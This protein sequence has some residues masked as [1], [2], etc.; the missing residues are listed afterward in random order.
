M[1]MKRLQK[2]K[3]IFH[4]F[5][6]A[7]Y[8]ALSLMAQNRAQFQTQGVRAMVL[9]VCL[10]L[11]LWIF[12]RLVVRDMEKA[13]LITSLT[14]ILFF[15]YGHVKNVI[16]ASRLPLDF[17]AQDAFLAPLWL[18]ILGFW[19]YWVVKKDMS[20]AR[21][22]SYFNGVG[23]I[24]ILFPLYSL[25]T[26]RGQSV[27]VDP[28][29][30][31][32]VA[33]TWLDS[34]VNDLEDRMASISTEPLPDI[35]LIVLD[36]YARADIL[37][38][39][40]GYDNSDFIAFLEERGF[41]VAEG[42]LANYTDT[43]LS[44]SSVLNMS[45]LSDMATFF[46]RNVGV[47]DEGVLRNVA[48]QMLKDNR[49][50][51]LLNQQGYSLVVFDSGYDPTTIEDADVF[52]QSLE[53]D[54]AG[55]WQVG[56]ELMLLDTSLGQIYLRLR[57]EDYAPLQKMFTAHRERVLFTLANLAKYADAEGQYFVYAHIVSPHTPYVFGP[58][59]EE[60]KGVDPYTLLDAHPGSEENIALYRGQVHHINSLLMQAIDQILERSDVPPIIILQSDHGGKVYRG[61]DPPNSMRMNLLFPILN[62]YHFPNG[63]YEQLY[64]TITPVNSFR[65]VFNT[66]FHTE[67]DLLDDNSYILEIK[68]G[69]AE[70]VDACAVYQACPSE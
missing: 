46:R 4:P 38:E 5:L 60:I 23:L 15:S 56:F 40:Y 52:V 41:Y 9:S 6:F 25:L 47:D 57:G 11:L 27:A 66:F 21:V 12:L 26:F 58:N 51:D 19:T 50:R 59:G 63:R 22:T 31:Q 36:A 37:E 17:F 67:L 42:S 62:A 7:S 20:V 48:T 55:L 43:E 69:R 65:V 61:L 28:W 16:L 18:F 2:W 10:S 44:V 14:V 45:H 70:F 13:S 53:V 35:Y 30:Q 1:V 34:D 54:E 3:W 68:D 29:V 32:F 33:Q 8:A 24:L 64:P 39:L 49:V